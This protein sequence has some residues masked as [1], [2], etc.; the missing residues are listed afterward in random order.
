MTRRSGASWAGADLG[1]TWLRVALAVGTARLRRT[2]RMLRPGESPEAALRRMLSAWGLRKVDSLVLGA[3]GAWHICERRRLAKAL[4]PI[5]G[6]IRVFSD[7]RIAWLAA[8]QNRP[9]VLVLAGTGSA[10]YGRDASGGRVRIGGLGP[11]LGDEGSAFWI[12]KRWAAG[13]PEETAW[14]LAHACDPVR[15][16]SA[17]ARGVLRRA[18]R[19]PRARRIASMPGQRDGALEMELAR[20]P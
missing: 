12:G 1:G 17:L 3:R 9:G 5:A 15:A 8:F 6:K 20:G 19:D 7:L 2:R 10:V 4:R 16:V 13:L 18:S 14:R 11:L